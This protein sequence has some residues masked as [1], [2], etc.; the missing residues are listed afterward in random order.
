MNASAETPVDFSA[1]AEL[2]QEIGEEVLGTFVTVFGDEVTRRLAELKTAVE[3]GDLESA[4]IE[5][6]TLKGAAGTYGAEWARG[7]AA[8]MEVAA[9]AGDRAFLE[10]NVSDLETRF[11]AAMT[12]LRARY[13]EAE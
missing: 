11:S 13:P 6:H 1:I 9:K 8:D 3:T 2:E 12:V 7:L 4:T 5:T 10:A